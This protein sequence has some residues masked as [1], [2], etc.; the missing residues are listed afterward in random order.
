M[1]QQFFVCCCFVFLYLLSTRY[2]ICFLFYFA[3]FF[4]WCI[5]NEHFCV[6]SCKCINVPIFFYCISFLLLMMYQIENDCK[7]YFIFFTYHSS[8]HQKSHLV[9]WINF[10]VLFFPLC[11]ERFL[12]WEN[13]TNY[14]ILIWFLK[15]K[16][17]EIFCIQWFVAIEKFQN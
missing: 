9:Y 4:C 11:A 13:A 8:F 15:D 6:F 5:I 17:K 1:Y 10:C 12:I 7:F 16:L 14:R 2:F 3:F